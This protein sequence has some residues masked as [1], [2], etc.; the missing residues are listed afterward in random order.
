MQHTKFKAISPLVP[1]Q[2]VFK[3]FYHIWL[4]R[5]YWSCDLDSLNIFSFLPLLQTL[6]EI[7]LQYAEWLLQEMFEIV[8]L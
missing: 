4:C 8:L 3:G 5:P 7:L 1:K 6:Y 2:K